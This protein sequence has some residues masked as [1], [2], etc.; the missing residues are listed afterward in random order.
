MHYLLA[1]STDLYPV[2]K[3][4]KNEEWKTASMQAQTYRIKK[5]SLLRGL[6]NEVSQ[7]GLGAETQ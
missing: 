5:R 4:Q 6:E 3:Q 2:E 7:R 1:T